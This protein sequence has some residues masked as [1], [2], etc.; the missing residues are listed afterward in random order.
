LRNEIN[1]EKILQYL[2]F[3]Q[4]FEL[5]EYCNKKGI[6]IIGDVPFYVSYDSSDVW[7]NPEIFKLTGSK[8][9]HFVAGVPPDLFSSTGQLWG[10]PVFNWKVLKETGYSWWLERIRHNLKLF[11]IVRLDHF[12]GFFDY[13]QVPAGNKTAAMGRWIKG[14]AEDFFKLLFRRFP[15]LPIIAEDLG[16]ITPRIRDFMEKSNIAGTRVIQFAFGKDGST[17]AHF[18]DNYVRNSIVYT[19]THD[20]NTIKGWFEKEADAGQKKRLCNY[21]GHKVHKENVNWE[22]INLASGSVANLVIIPLQDVLGLGQEAR[23][24]RP[25]KQSG[26]WL[27]RFRKGQIK[28]QVTLKLK[29]LTQ[30]NGRG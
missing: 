16:Y 2:F 18:P 27:W 26:N 30:T 20:N 3:R 1:R 8:K 11:D 23:M 14:H 10:N 15:N 7:S 29:Q 4:W 17:K 24:N 21:L 25:G 13:W 6:R 12:R 5:K 28:P 9:P 19:G 22:L